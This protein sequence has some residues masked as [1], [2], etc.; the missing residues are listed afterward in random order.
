MR[1]LLDSHVLIWS[2]ERPER[3]ARA[4]AEAIMDRDN[5]VLVSVAT[6]WELAI[7]Q[8]IG[9]LRVDVDL[10]A[11]AGTTGFDELPVLGAHAAAVRDLPFHHR[12]P[13]DRMLVAQAQVEGLT[14]VTVDR[15]LS[16]YD[17]PIMQA[18]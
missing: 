2:W 8:S 4:T 17:V 3:L 12:D 15:A 9:K 14:L 16:A 13:F 1:L 7:K 18:S 6:I 10:R 11:H 5:D